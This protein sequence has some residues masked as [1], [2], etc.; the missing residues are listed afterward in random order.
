[1]S[2][3]AEL[4]LLEAIRLEIRAAADVIAARLRDSMASSK[5]CWQLRDRG[6]KLSRMGFDN[7]NLAN[8]EKEAL[9]HDQT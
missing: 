4:L 9:G 5:R 8:D 1:M 3:R 6:D 7:T 2:D